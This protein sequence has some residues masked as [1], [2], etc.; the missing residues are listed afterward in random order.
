MNVI[1][2]C[3][4]QDLSEA[5]LVQIDTD[6]PPILDLNLMLTDASSLGYGGVLLQKKDGKFRAVA[7]YSKRTTITE[8]KYHSLLQI[9]MR[10]NHRAKSSILLREYIGGGRFC[11]L[12]TLTSY[13]DQE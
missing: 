7:Y 3:Q 1:N 6:A 8:S 9:L 12:L 10:Y 13:I 2:S 11:N 4:A 5:D